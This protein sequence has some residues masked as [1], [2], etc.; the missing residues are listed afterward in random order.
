MS[1]AT[2]VLMLSATLAAQSGE[3]LGPKPVDLVGKV[4][5][6]GGGPGGQAQAVLVLDDGSEWTL[7]STD[8]EAQ[9][10]LV[11]LSGVRAHFRG[12]LGDPRFPGT[13]AVS[14]SRY[15]IVD[16]GKGVVP[17]IGHLASLVLDGKTR[18]LFVDEAGTAELLPEGYAEK[19]MKQ[20]GAKLWMVGNKSG[21][22]FQPMRFAILRSAAPK[23]GA[24]P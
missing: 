16:I 24:L 4:R 10:E 5:E 7:W 15:E 1:A 8:P 20:V 19:L 14:V 13:N 12:H 11:R 23:Q 18:L 22:R 2:L 21:E 17:R 3:A 6:V 9:G